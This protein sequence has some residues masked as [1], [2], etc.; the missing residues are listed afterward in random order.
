MRGKLTTYAA[1]CLSVALCGLMLWG[2]AEGLMYVT[3][4]L[5]ESEPTTQL[6]AAIIMASLIIS[7]GMPSCACCK[8]D[9][10]E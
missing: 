6:C 1:L 7:S 4:A 3:R 10:D 5:R 2:F 9:T 8:G